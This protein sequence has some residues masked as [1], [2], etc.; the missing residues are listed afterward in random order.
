MQSF[1]NR[2]SEMEVYL[3]MDGILYTSAFRNLATVV[4]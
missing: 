2:S 3:E 1:S 4:G